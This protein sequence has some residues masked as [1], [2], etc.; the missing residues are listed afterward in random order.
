[1]MNIIQKQLLRILF[2]QEN[3]N[4]Y[5]WHQITCL[6]P[7]SIANAVLS[8]RKDGLLLL[9]DNHENACLTEYGR[10]WI[11]RNSKEL[12]ASKGE[13]PWKNVPEEMGSAGDTIF[14]TFYEVSDL[15]RLLDNIN[16]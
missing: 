12:F 2:E 13:E 3:I 4:I 1:M 7:I 5:A 10:K 8:L 6:S 11:E 9:S 16:E 15:Q 14:H